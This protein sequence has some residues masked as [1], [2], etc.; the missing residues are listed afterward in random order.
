MWVPVP[1]MRKKEK[2]VCDHEVMAAMLRSS[3]IL[4]L[5]LC[6]D[7]EPYIV[8][9]CFGYEE[10]GV[11]FVHSAREGRKLDIIRRHDMVCFEVDHMDKL[12]N[13]GLACKWTMDYHSII[14]TGKASLVTEPDQIKRALDVI[15]RHYGGKPPFEYSEV[16]LSRMLIIR[17]DIIGMTCK[18]SM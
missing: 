5:G 14:G 12:V 6:D 10:G 16:S 11:I 17:I 15:M 3:D 2:E 18:R 7:G 1:T 8:P 13:K 9:V 4:R